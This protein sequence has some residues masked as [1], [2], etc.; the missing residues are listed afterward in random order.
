N[1]ALT[2]SFLCPILSNPRL[3]TFSGCRITA[4]KG[5]CSDVA[6]GNRELLA[7]VFRDHADDRLSQR[8]GVPAIEDIT[9]NGRAV[10]A[11]DGDVAAIIKGGFKRGEQ[12]LLTCEFGH[13]TFNRCV[14]RSRSDF[15]RFGIEDGGGRLGLAHAVVSSSSLEAD[16]PAAFSMRTSGL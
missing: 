6:I 14:G 13:P 11:S 3:P 10:L 2:R 9:F 15:E 1:T 7:R 5:Q 12:I 4:R 8:S 16:S